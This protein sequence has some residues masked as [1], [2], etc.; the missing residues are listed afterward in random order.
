MGSP[1]P[2]WGRMVGAWT[3]AC[4][5]VRLTVNLTCGGTVGAHHDAPADSLSVRRFSNARSSFAARPKKVHFFRKYGLQNKS[6]R[7]TIYRV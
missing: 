3:L 2:T 1:A 6:V 4:G 7:D 5:E